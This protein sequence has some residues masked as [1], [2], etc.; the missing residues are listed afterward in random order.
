MQHGHEV[1]GRHFRN[2]RGF[3]CGAGEPGFDDLFDGFDVV[4][5]FFGEVGGADRVDQGVRGA[6][7]GVGD[8]SRG[9]AA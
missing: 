7:F 2:R 5:A 9:P 4:V 6:Q 3:G 1:N 8:G